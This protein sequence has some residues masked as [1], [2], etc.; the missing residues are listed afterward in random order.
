[1]FQND[2][3]FHVSF[4]LKNKTYFLE[5]FFS[6]INHLYGPL[7]NHMERSHTIGNV[8]MKIFTFPLLNF[9]NV[10]RDNRRCMN[11]NVTIHLAT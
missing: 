11:A 8:C 4:I 7:C 6:S 5:S 2:R 9:Q 3:L 10:V 1:M